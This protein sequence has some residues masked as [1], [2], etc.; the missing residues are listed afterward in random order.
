MNYTMLCSPENKAQFHYNEFTEGKEIDRIEMVLREGYGFSNDKIKEF[1][2][3]YLEFAF[4]NGKRAIGTKIGDNI[5]EILFIDTNH[6]ICIDSCRN[7]KQKMMYEYPSL[8]DTYDLNENYNEY[9]KEN[10]IAML[11]EDAEKGKYKE[12]TEFIND[13]KGIFEE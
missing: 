11:I 3:L 9:D 6:M 13:C 2:R 10:L 5:I 7:P 4:S 8:F 1:E 12:L